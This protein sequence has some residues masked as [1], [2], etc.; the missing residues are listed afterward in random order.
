[1]VAIHYS[2]ITLG[3]ETSKEVDWHFINGR[4]ANLIWPCCCFGLPCLVGIVANF[5]KTGLRL[6]VSKIANQKMPRGPG[7]C[8][9]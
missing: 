7:V 4:T 3:F 6:F 5:G 8:Q 2:E 9:K 1:M